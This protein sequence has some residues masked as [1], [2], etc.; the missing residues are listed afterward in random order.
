M[1][2]TRMKHWAGKEAY[3]TEELFKVVESFTVLVPEW[4]L[5]RRLSEQLITAIKN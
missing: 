1:Y 4:L 3:N 5:T 2:N